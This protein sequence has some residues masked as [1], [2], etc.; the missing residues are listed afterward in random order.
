M[1]TPRKRPS[2]G[3]ARFRAF[4]GS[5]SPSAT[6]SIPYFPR[7]SVF[8]LHSEEDE[9]KFLRSGPLVR[10]PVTMGTES[11]DARFSAFETR[12]LSLEKTNTLLKAKVSKLE[13][14]NASLEVKTKHSALEADLVTSKDDMGNRRSQPLLVLELTQ[15]LSTFASL[16]GNGDDPSEPSG[17]LERRELRGNDIQSLVGSEGK[18]LAGGPPPSGDQFIQTSVSMTITG[19]PAIEPID[20]GPVL[21]VVEDIFAKA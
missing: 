17:F 21:A 12:F 16:E 13:T 6:A 5:A 2:L 8:E 11:L 20:L 18:N 1:S 7:S 4:P 14:R 19:R 3:S 10:A 15:N 9:V